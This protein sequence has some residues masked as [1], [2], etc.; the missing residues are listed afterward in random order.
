MLAFADLDACHVPWFRRRESRLSV[1][2]RAN[3][4]NGARM[5]RMCV[6]V[7]YQAVEF[8]FHRAIAAESFTSK[9]N[10]PN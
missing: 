6:S 8:Q 10:A 5:P 7:G 2:Y 3:H 4:E 9:V 1:R